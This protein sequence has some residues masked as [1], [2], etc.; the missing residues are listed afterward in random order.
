MVSR[1]NSIPHVVGLMFNFSLNDLTVKFVRVVF[2]VFYI[3]ANKS[4]F[5]LMYTP[6]GRQKQSVQWA[7]SPPIDYRSY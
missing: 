5:M 1:F 3:H 4:I 7:G 6:K 2:L